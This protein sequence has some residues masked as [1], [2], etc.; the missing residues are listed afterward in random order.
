MASHSITGT[1]AA[2]RPLFLAVALACGLFVLLTLL[3]M[4]SYPGGTY[5]DHGS[6]GFSLTS[7][8]FSDLGR[9]RTRLGGPQ[10]ASRVLFTAALLL[11]AGALMTFFIAFAG[12][13]RY[14][15]AGRLF[16]R[17]G[18]VLGCIA[19]LCF[20]GVALVP[21]DV[22]LA[23]HDELVQWAFRSYLGAVLCYIVALGGQRQLPARFRRLFIGFALLLAAYVLLI[24]FGPSVREPG[25]QTIQATGQKIIVFAAILC[26]ALES[27]WAWRYT[28]GPPAGG[29]GPP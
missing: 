28:A 17:G 2:V 22:N 15:R 25:G 12:L 13:V 7:N 29:R 6:E 11:V 10:A 5:L 20:A 26:V 27:L 24:S 19:G 23:L 21:S 1:T 8:F 16:S 14:E 18:S 9:T 3:A 4:L